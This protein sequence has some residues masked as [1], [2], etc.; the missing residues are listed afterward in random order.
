M[1]LGKSEIGLSELLREIAGRRERGDLSPIPDEERAAADPLTEEV[2][3]LVTGSHMRP[4][5][6]QRIYADLV[7]NEELLARSADPRLVTLI[8]WGEHVEALY[9]AYANGRLAL[10]HYSRAM[11]ATCRRCR[12]E[13][14]P[15][16]TKLDELGR[17]WAAG[18][19]AALYELVSPH[20]V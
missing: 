11:E 16:M 17:L 10:F 2:L 14:L 7:G 12:F 5:H 8:L 20:F 3:F 18:D 6:R 19:Y 15:L 1:G 9:K 4:E 13:L